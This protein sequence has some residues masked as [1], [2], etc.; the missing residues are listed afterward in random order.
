MAW[1]PLKDTPV[2]QLLGK[3]AKLQTAVTELVTKE[4]LNDARARILSVRA[5]QHTRAARKERM[6]EKE[7]DGT[8]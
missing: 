2:L 3:L 1:V 8:N 5:V 6:R 7:Q 4:K